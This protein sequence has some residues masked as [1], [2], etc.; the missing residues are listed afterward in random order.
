MAL[1][2]GCAIVMII[3]VTYFIGLTSSSPI[4]ELLK[5]GAG[6]AF[7][8]LFNQNNY[9]IQRII[10]SKKKETKLSEMKVILII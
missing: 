3:Y 8:N 4:S 7:Y 2:V 9:T 6:K 10:F 5:D 1:I